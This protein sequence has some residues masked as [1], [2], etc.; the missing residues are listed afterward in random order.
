MRPAPERA[1]RA[2]VPSSHFRQIPRGQIPRP[3]C[4]APALGRP[5]SGAPPV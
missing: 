3:G 2:A 5:V 1:G 4:P